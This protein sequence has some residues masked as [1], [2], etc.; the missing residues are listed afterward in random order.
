MLVRVL[1]ITRKE[2]LHIIQ[3]RR[4]QAVMF[5]ILVIQLLLMGYAATTDIK[6][7]KTAVWDQDH[8]AHSRALMEA[9]RASNYFNIRYYVSSEDELGGAV[10]LLSAARFRKRLD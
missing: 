1:S 10:M 8:T 7:L 2:F 9:Y 3:D 4:T 5:L 6:H